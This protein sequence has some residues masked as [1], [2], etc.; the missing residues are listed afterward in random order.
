MCGLDNTDHDQ[1]CVDYYFILFY[2][3]YFILRMSFP[4]CFHVLHY[5][6]SLVMGVMYSGYLYDT[7]TCIYVP[8]TRKVLG[9]ELGYT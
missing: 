4:C 5:K 2:F 8:G 7:A 9:L 3:I 1:I 6:Y